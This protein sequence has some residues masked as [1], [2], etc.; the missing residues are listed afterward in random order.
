MKIKY[1]DT[2]QSIEI[3]DGLRTQYWFLNAMSILNIIN[4]ILFPVFVLEKKQFQWMGFFWVIIGLVSAG[5]LFYQLFKK[6]ASEKIKLDEIRNLKEKDFLG[7]KKLSLSLTNGRSRDLLSLKKHSD[8]SE[9]KRFFQE[10]G[11]TT[12]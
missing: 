4:S 1:N 7:R 10:L 6:S 12:A 9:T 5:L 11:I 3:D 8:I 2:H